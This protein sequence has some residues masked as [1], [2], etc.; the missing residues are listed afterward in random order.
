MTI[1]KAFSSYG[2]VSSETTSVLSPYFTRIS[3][4]QGTT[5]WRKGDEPDAMY[6][7]ESGVLR[8]TYSFKEGGEIVPRDT[9]AEMES[10]SLSDEHFE[11]M[12]SGAI[13]GELSFLSGMPRNAVVYV[14]RDAVLWKLD[15]ES[16]DRL[17]TD[18]REFA[19]YF[20]RLVLKGAR[21]D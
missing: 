21:F 10:P 7:I 1:I 6:I 4:P 14:E 20:V 8:A 19:K 2:D 5:L 9:R 11:S 12:V 16:L 18:D 3:L 13:T 15:R 17:E